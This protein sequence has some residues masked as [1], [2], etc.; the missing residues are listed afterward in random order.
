MWIW[1]LALWGTRA[2]MAT[3]GESAPTRRSSMRTSSISVALPSSRRTTALVGTALRSNQRPPNFRFLFLVW[4][5]INSNEAYTRRWLFVIVFLILFLMDVWI[6][7]VIVP[8]FGW[9]KLDFLG[10]RRV[11]ITTRMQWGIRFWEP[12]PPTTTTVQSSNTARLLR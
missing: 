3:T 11:K 2:A 8:S 5:R 10:L 1:L 12:H 6:I 9:L 7:G 4:R